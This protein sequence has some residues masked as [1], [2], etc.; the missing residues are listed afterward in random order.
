MSVL[1]EDSPRPYM[2]GWIIDSVTNG[3]GS[4]AVITPWA[5]PFLHHPGQGQKP[6]LHNRISELRA[7]GV[8]VLFDPMTH[9]LQMSGVGDFRYYQEYDLWLGPQGDL[10]DQAFIEGHV[11]KVFRL[12]D[13]LEV[14]H[15]APTVLL[16]AGLE[17][18]SVI[19]LDLARE[20]IRLDSGAVLSIA[21]TPPFW[22][23]GA[24]LD[25]H[26]GALASL[27]PAGWVVTVVRTEADLPATVQPE[28]VHGLCRTTR[29]LSEIAPVHTSH[30]DVAALPA[31]A[32]GASTV[33]SGWDQ[34]Q[35][36][37]AYGHYGARDPDAGGGG[38]YR[39]PTLRGLLGS[40]TPNEAIV[41]NSRAPDVVA[42]LGG[43]PPPGVREAFDHHVATLSQV[44]AALNAESNYEA[45]YRMLAAMYDAAR[46]DWRTVHREANTTLNAQH[47]IDGVAS[48]LALYA[49]TEGWF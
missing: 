20:A 17:I 45:K 19:A 34:R 14:P 49:G 46:V 48:G 6:S 37:C 1:I 23:S 2:A 25:A 10:S 16:H 15:Y 8:D 3:F 27:D 33:G 35:R 38:W 26:I 42:R 31:V 22:A 12:Q 43:L 32:A 47:W 11:D 9:V 5:T 44:V 18:T 29:A 41:L 36:V 28:E 24:A 40:I 7:S 4:G 21:G 13:T 39:R 30:G